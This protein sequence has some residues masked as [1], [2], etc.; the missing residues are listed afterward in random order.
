VRASL[1]SLDPVDTRGKWGEAVI[2]IGLAC[3]N[4]TT[5]AALRTGEGQQSIEKLRFYLSGEPQ[6]VNPLYEMIFNHATRVEIHPGQNTGGSLRR[7]RKLPKLQVSPIVLPP[8]SLKQV[9]FEDDE[10]LLE[11]TARSFSGYRLLSEYFSLPEKFSFVDVTSLGA[12]STDGFDKNFEIHIYLKDVT[13]PR[14]SI[15]ADTFQLG[16]TP[17]INLFNEITEP[18]HLSAKQHE[19]QVIP[20]V[21]RQIAT[22]IYSIDS[23]VADDP[24]Q[25]K[26]REFHPFYSFRHAREQEKDRTFWYASRRPSLRPEDPGTE[27]YLSLV[28]LGFNPHVPASTVLTVRASCTNRDLPARLPWGGTQ[29]DLEVEGAAPLSRIHCLT[30][31]TETLR[32]PL[33]RATQ[34]RL[35]SHLSLNHLSLGD[36]A[37]NG[38]PDALQEI[39][40][41]YD[42]TE[43]S[44]TR[45]QITGIN[46]VTS[47]RV[48]RQTGSRIGSGFVRGIQTTIEF[49]EEQYVGSGLFLF[50]SVL[51]R[52][53]ALYAS[54][55]SFNE[56]VAVT[57]QREG[58]MKQWP[59]RTGEQIVL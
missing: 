43:S 22:E 33:R 19:Y 26:S 58:I 37:R 8:S 12:T 54:I 34:W 50:S 14:G 11:Y 36:G 2:K 17:V 25:A 41:L 32:P 4:E 15:G 55:N 7:T 30:K 5:L 52:F 48:V 40:F 49:D 28:D 47:R 29:G 53:L 27:V 51:E 10:A 44:A 59:P 46:R 57:K 56:L 45:H 39:L 16:C 1:E 20:D 18:I 6:L 21:R 31:P 23:V 38:A 42:L 35:L 13:P 3:M 24:Q 9:G